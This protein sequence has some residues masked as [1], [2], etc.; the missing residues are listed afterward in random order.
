MCVYVFVCVCYTFNILSAHMGCPQWV[1][2]HGV[3]A[4]TLAE[5]AVFF[6]AEARAAFLV[7]KGLVPLVCKDFGKR[8]IEKQQAPHTVVSSPLGTLT[9]A[10]NHSLSIYLSQ[11]IIHC[12]TTLTNDGCEL[13]KAHSNFSLSLSLYLYVSPS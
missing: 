6:L 5:L 9:A 1:T 8:L 11:I 2:H 10:S 3:C 7:L 13:F 4:L 12:V